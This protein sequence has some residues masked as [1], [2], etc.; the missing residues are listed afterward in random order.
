MS[1][2]IYEAAARAGLAVIALCLPLCGAAF[3]AMGVPTPGEM[4]MQ[5]PASPVAVEIHNFYNLVTWIIIVISLFVMGLLAIVIVRFNARANPVPS[6]T[7][8][9]T[10]LEVAWTV[11]PILVL[12][13]I[14]IPSFKLLNLQYSFP[15]PDLVIKA[16]ANAWFWE[17]Q[18]VDKGGFTVTTNMLHDEDI[19]RADIGD[20]EF[21]KRY[22][23]V[24]DGLGKLKMLYD[25]AK[26]LYAKHGQLRQLAVDNEIA[27]PVNKV[28]HLLVTSNDVIHQWTIPSFGSKLQAVPGR[29]SATWFKA[30]HTGVYYGQCSVI[31]G[32]DHSSMPIVVRVVSE[33]VFNDWAAAM[34]ARDTKKAKSI[35]KAEADRQGTQHA[36]VAEAH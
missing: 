34:K 14:A 6:R 15:K 17:H 13:V 16:T 8:H 33:P 20:K 35:L 12:V 18:F 30:T 5:D 7:T 21:D 36:R 25:D 4:V 19:I 10:L 31:C 32:R 28:V 23:S 9:N 11:I 26:P 27:V 2:R 22:G 3:A 1:R 24:P 29:V